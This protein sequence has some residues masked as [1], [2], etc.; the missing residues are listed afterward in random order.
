MIVYQ[1]IT[2]VKKSKKCKY[3]SIKE[4]QMTNFKFLIGKKIRF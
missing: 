3:L 1:L 4:L 2:K